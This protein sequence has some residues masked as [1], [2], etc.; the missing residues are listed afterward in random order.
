M[1]MD[2]GGRRHAPLHW[3]GAVERE[4]AGNLDVGGSAAPASGDTGC[5]FRG[6]REGRRGGDRSG[7]HPTHGDFLQLDLRPTSVNLFQEDLSTFLNTAISGSGTT[8]P[9]R[10]H[11]GCRAAAAPGRAR[12]RPE[13][14]ALRFWNQLCR[15]STRAESTPARRRG[16]LSAG[17]RDTEEASNP[18]DVL[19]HSRGWDAPLGEPRAHRELSRSPFRGHASCSN[20]GGA[21]ETAA[22]ETRERREAQRR[23]DGCGG[24][25][26]FRPDVG[27]PR[28]ATRSTRRLG[29]VSAPARIPVDR[30]L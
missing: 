15:V 14:P 7:A 22:F 28:R 23:F 2:R 5:R 1:R 24:D 29:G 11:C 10:R 20:S 18:W 4:A 16:P 3:R 8:S 17:A 21:A 13:I 19:P 26:S 25:P 27:R 30:M 9:D 6:A 12:A